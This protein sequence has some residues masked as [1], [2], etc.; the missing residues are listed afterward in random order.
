MKNAETGTEEE[1]LVLK[2]LLWQFGK[3]IP[4]GL[5]IGKEATGWQM[6]IPKC[7]RLSVG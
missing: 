1:V 5:F 4:A 7:T 6:S 2:K 3:P